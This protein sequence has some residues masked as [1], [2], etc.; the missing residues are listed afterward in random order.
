MTPDTSGR[1]LRVPLAHYD[2]DS[3]SWRTSQGMFPSGWPT[4]SGTCPR[5]GMTRRGELFE[6]PTP[7][8]PTVGPGSSSSRNL[9]TPTTHTWKESGHCRDWGSDLTHAISCG[10]TR[11]LPTPVVNDMGEG[12]SPEAWDAWTESMR[13]RH[14]NGNG[15]GPSLAIEAQRLLPTP[16]AAVSSDGITEEQAAARALERYRGNLV[17]SVL[18]LPTPLASD[19]EKGGPNQ[20]GGSGDLR[21]SSAVQLLPTPSLADAMGGHLTRSGSRSDELLLPGVAEALANGDLTDQPS[22]DGKPSS[23]DQLPG[24]LSLDATAD[25][26]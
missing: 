22:G 24:Q 23:D 4:S 8:L 19:G 6:L 13:A 12:K 15:H 16:T 25:P 11:L 10:C 2:P 5:W 18:L 26:D 21:L 17:E 20:R 1:A 14:G 3:S 7:A 9:P